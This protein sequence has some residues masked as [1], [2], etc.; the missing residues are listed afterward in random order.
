MVVMIGT[1]ENGAIH[2]RGDVTLPEHGEVYVA[3]P[4]E[5]V[6]IAG[7]RSPR[8]A[9]PVDAPLFDKQVL[10]LDGDPV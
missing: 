9:D 2:L 6:P 3:V 1:I 4:G 7:L 5:G 8:L 10:D